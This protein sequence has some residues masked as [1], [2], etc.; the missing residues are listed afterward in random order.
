MREQRIVIIA[1]CKNAAPYIKAHIKSVAEQTVK[2]YG[3]IICFATDD[4]ISKN[5][6]MV[7]LEC[8]GL[9]SAYNPAEYNSTER[10][11]RIHFLDVGDKPS[12][13][14]LYE[15]LTD[16]KLVQ[17]SDI[18]VWLDGTDR[19]ATPFALARVLAE[20][21][22]DPSILCTYGNFVGSKGSPSN[23]R[24]YDRH[25][26]S[27]G[28]I[29][30][31]PWLASHLRTFRAH[32]FQQIHKSDL[33]D[34]TGITP[35]GWFDRC[36]DWVVM[37]PILEMARLRASFIP[38]I[39]VEYNEDDMHP[40]REEYE[41]RQGEIIQALPVYEPLAVLPGLFWDTDDQEKAKSRPYV[42]ATMLVGDSSDVRQTS[43]N[44]QSLPDTIHRVVVWTGSGQWNEAIT[45]PGIHK[46]VN[47]TWQHDFA[48]ARNEC[49]AIAQRMGA[50]WCLSIDSDEEVHLPKDW[51]ARLRKLEAYDV[52]CT[53]DET[54]TYLRNTFQR[55]PSVLRYSGKTHECLPKEA[56]KALLV[57][58]WVKETPKSEAEDFAKYERD[59][60]YVKAELKTHPKDPRWH[61]YLAGALCYGKQWEE[62]DYEFQQAFNLYEEPAEKAWAAYQLGSLH[63]KQKNY[64]VALGWFTKAFLTDGHRP[65]ILARMA[66]CCRMLGQLGQALLFAQIAV[67]MP[68]PHGYAVTDPVWQRVGPWEVVETVLED[69]GNE[70]GWKMAAK[71][72]RGAMAEPH[73]Q[74]ILKAAKS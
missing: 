26:L 66:Q 48:A 12:L 54:K 64:S 23:L 44:M 29:R 7:A 4:K 30:K 68:I 6:R 19:L 5:S 22:N 71:A 43:L 35:S 18:I 16:E 40:T 24:A 13:Q 45:G 56:T 9:L 63:V 14:N 49:L 37:F 50:T 39:L 28:R 58:A 17:P 55:V 62:A 59:F 1:T 61:F 69:Q 11:I 8:A 53:Q 47:W 32:V 10:S 27:W 20:Y 65:E 52:V 42:V 38:D 57:G 25:A 34:N 33:Q 3:H 67:N 41:L 46:I 73:I 15:Q 74:A 36:T 51:E 60:S 2:P 70:E 72:K 21:T 31:E